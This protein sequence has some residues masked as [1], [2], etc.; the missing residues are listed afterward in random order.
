MSA[1]GMTRR[2]S[3]CD[4]KYEFVEKDSVLH[5]Y[6]HG[7]E[8]RDFVGDKAIHALFDLALAELAH[9]QAGEPAAW[10]EHHKGGDNLTWTRLDHP[11][12]KATPLYAAP[13]AP[14]AVAWK[15]WCGQ[16][17]RPARCE[18]NRKCDRNLPA[19]PSSPEPYDGLTISRELDIADAAKPDRTLLTDAEI[20]AAW[21]AAIPASK[22]KGIEMYLY[23]MSGRCST[24]R[25]GREDRE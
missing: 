7:H 5:C 14:S 18:R 15:E 4:G 21:N 8:W 24:T 9:E 10:I 2:L 6:R 17:D 3:L 1:E 11:Y 16:C 19:A 22:D 23:L 13:P 25:Q 12:A 20:V